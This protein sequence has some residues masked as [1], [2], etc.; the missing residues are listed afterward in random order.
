VNSL[1]QD[2]EFSPQVTALAIR[3]GDALSK[4]ASL[5]ITPQSPNNKRMNDIFRWKNVIAILHELAVIA[6]TIDWHELRDAELLALGF[7][8]WKEDSP[9]RLVP[10]HLYKALPQGLK[11]TAIDGEVVTVGEGEIDTDTR[12]GCIPYGLIGK[13]KRVTGDTSNESV[14]VS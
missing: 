5:D 14:R 4:I 12:L 8:L 10:A 13:D 6:R 9:L 11:L 3:Y 2:L 1:D 7:K